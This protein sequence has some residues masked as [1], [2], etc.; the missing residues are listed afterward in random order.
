M[1]FQQT[2][3]TEEVK[4]KIKN[5][6]SALKDYI[7]T[8]LR[9]YKSIFAIKKLD[10]DV[11]FEREGDDPFKSGYSSSVSIGISENNGELIDLYI[12]KI[13]ECEHSFFGMPISKKIIG[14]K[15]IGELMDETIEET[16]EEMKDFIEDFLEE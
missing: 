2:D 1:K 13:W 5:T 3:F 11:G 4:V 7:E 16:K 15:I 9:E 8:L 12:I 6:E 14:S 10:L